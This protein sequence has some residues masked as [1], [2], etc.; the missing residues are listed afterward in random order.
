MH[1]YLD[2]EITKIYTSPLDYFKGLYNSDRVR[3]ICLFLELF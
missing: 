1:K 2:A 3:D